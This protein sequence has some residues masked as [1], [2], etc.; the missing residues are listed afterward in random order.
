[1]KKK[2]TNNNNPA[3][4]HDAKI[5]GRHLS[6]VFDNIDRELAI[7]RELLEAILKIVQSIEVHTRPT[8]EHDATVV[9]V[10]Q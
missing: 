8:E 3:T 9:A 2:A 7:H 1:M 6:S 5:R 4:Q 10:A